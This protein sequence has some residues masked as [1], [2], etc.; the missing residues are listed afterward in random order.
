MGQLNAGTR[1]HLAAVSAEC[2]PVI[3]CPAGH[4]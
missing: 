1:N 2:N 4:G 3:E